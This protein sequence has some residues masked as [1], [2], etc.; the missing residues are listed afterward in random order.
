MKYVI[1]EDGLIYKVK[2]ALAEEVSKIP[3]DSNETAEMEERIRIEGKYIG[4]VYANIR[5]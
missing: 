1:I 3:S 5:L 4:Q 2:D